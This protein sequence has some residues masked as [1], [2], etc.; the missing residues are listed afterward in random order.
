[1]SRQ[2]KSPVSAGT[3]TGA[4]SKTDS[5]I[6]QNN[7][8]NTAQTQALSEPFDWGKAVQSLAFIVDQISHQM[9]V[10]KGNNDLTS[11]G[12]VLL[13]CSGLF[14][15]ERELQSIIEELSTII[16]SPMEQEEVK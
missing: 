9:L 3:G 6:C 16:Q 2:K 11:P 1:M 7:T 4:G 15:L 5:S 8:T 13:G 14:V 12:W 10:A